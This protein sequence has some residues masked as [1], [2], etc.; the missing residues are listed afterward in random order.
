MKTGTK[1]FGM[2]SGLAKFRR[3]LPPLEYDTTDRLIAGL[4][5]EV[6]RP[7]TAEG[8]RLLSWKE[9]EPRTRRVRNSVT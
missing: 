8:R 2:F 9:H 4:D 6:I 7:A 3:I 5:D 1:P